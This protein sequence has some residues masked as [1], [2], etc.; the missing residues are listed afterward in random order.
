MTT[1]TTPTE[2]AD[3]STTE[4]LVPGLGNTPREIQGLEMTSTPHHGESQDDSEEDYP[5]SAMDDMDWNHLEQFPLEGTIIRTKQGEETPLL[6]RNT[7][8][9]SGQ[10]TLQ[11]NSERQQDTSTNHKWG[12]FPNP[13][14]LIKNVATNTTDCTM[15]PLKT[16]WINR[17]PHFTTTPQYSHEEEH[18]FTEDDY[19][20]QE[21]DNL[22][23]EVL[24]HPP[25]RGT[26]T[27]HERNC[28]LSLSATCEQR[29]THLLLCPTK[30]GCKN[31]FPRLAEKS[32]VVKDYGLR[33]GNA[34]LI[35]NTYIAGGKIIAV[36]SDACE[37]ERVAVHQNASGSDG[38][39]CKFYVSGSNPENQCHLY[40]VPC[41]DA[42][43][44]LSTEITPSLRHLL[45]SRSEWKG[46]GQLRITHA[47]SD[48]KTLSYSS[49]RCKRCRKT[50]TATP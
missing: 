36:F 31:S 24:E 45:Q 3:S 15:Q 20:D 41:E 6:P 49:S 7:L 33:S 10:D 17:D 8:P 35:S 28:P 5:E 14:L 16:P 43:L 30:C 38:K 29:Q 22:D 13:T 37:F 9:H 46:V 25:H 32:R 21:L 19:S 34:E 23:W 11:R 39:T 18:R 27:D 26:I 48:T 40:V 44:A 47:A 4:D 50:T 42:D 12:V 1:T 2:I